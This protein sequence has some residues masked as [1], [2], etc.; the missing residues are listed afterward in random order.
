MQP[1]YI[2]NIS[3]GRHL[4][5][6]FDFS[7][8]A[9]IHH[10]EMINPEHFRKGTPNMHFSGFNCILTLLIFSNVSHMSVRRSLTLF[11]SRMILSTKKLVSKETIDYLLEFRFTFSG[12][13]A[14]S[15]NKKFHHLLRR[16]FL[17]YLPRLLESD[18]ILCIHLGSKELN[19]PLLRPPLA[20]EMPF[21]GCPCSDPCNL[22]TSFIHHYV[23]APLQDLLTIQSNRCA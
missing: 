9:F 8:F 22:Y 12:Q 23:W 21:M 4:L 6:S 1:L 3:W 19:V 13:K 2:P 5:D 17:P 10:S 14:S 18:G 7:T 15:C 11:G 20:K 16:L